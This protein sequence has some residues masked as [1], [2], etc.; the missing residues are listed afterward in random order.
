[1]NDPGAMNDPAPLDDAG[2]RPRRQKGFAL[3]IVL[4]TMGFLALIGT[5]I[6]AAARSDTRLAGNLKQEAVLQAAADGAVENVMFAMQ[7]ARTPQ[8]R[9]D[10]VPRELRIG[11]TVVAVRVEK[12]SDRVN[13]NTAAAALLRALMV[14]VG[15]APALAD[16]LSAAILDWRTA[17]TNARN[18]GAKAPQYQAAGL[19]YAPPGTPFQSVEELVQVL[20]MTPA[21]LERLA[22]HLTVLTDGDPDMTT[23]DPVVSR[24]LTDASGIADDTSGASTTFDDV[25]RI[26][27][28]A[29]GRDGARYSLLVVA[30]ANFQNAA[31]RVNILLRQRL[32]AAQSKIPMSDRF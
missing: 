7:A 15:A 12:E 13:L 3:L 8:F 10:G 1:M 29:T 19:S 18:G 6:V 27:A 25:L 20:G 11:D 17:G 9:A 32:T 14:Q 2:D 5:Q 16:R 24:A 21:L 28:T 4:L 22:P 23:R 26:V 30:S 31:P